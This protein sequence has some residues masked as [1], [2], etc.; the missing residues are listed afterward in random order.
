MTYMKMSGG[1]GGTKD[2]AFSPEEYRARVEHVRAEM[3]RR[4][5]DVLLV[6]TPENVLYLSGFRTPGY[7]A[8]QCLI[9]TMQKD[10]VLFIRNGEFG[11]AYAYSWLD[12]CLTY[13]DSERPE[14]ATL[15]ALAECGIERG[16]VGLEMTSWFITPRVYESV[17]S[18]KQDVRWADGSGTV[19]ACRVRKS[20]KEIEYIRHAARAAEAGMRAAIEEAAPGKTDNDVAAAVS[21]AMIRAGSEY[22]ALGPFV[23]AGRRSSIMHGIWERRP[24]GVG[25]PIILEIGGVIQRYNAA[26]MRTVCVGK[27]PAEL[28]AMAAASESANRLL[29]EHIKPGAMTADLHGI[30]MGELERHGFAGTRKGRRCGYSIGLAFAPDWGEGHIISMIDEPNLPLEPGMV[31]HLP[32]SVR[33]YG[34]YGASFSETVL[35]TEAG[36]EVLTN[37]ERRLFVKAV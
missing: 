33:L 6:H 24:L 12:G 37:F 25:E 20:P 27:P 7:Y 32:L 4:E 15:R 13:F 19:E 36:H 2:L 30:C 31:F 29:I 1:E 14:E 16:T 17:R 18:R 35:V 5:L 23:A 21:G 22:P 10:P 8:Y 26:L 28:E 9:V 34:K 11:N 3:R